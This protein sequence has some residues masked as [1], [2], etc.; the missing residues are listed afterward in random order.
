MDDDHA[1]RLAREPYA[2]PAHALR[3]SGHPIR[4][5]TIRR[6]GAAAVAVAVALLLP[7]A[8]AAAGQRPHAVQDALER[9]V[10]AGAPGAVALAGDR[11]FA[12]GVADAGSGRRLRAGDRVRIGSVTKSFVAVVAL[13]LAGEGRLGL[14][15]TLGRRL[16]GVLPYGDDITLRQL[17]NH[18]SGVPDDVV[19]ALV[20][21]FTGDPLRVW[22][23][24]EIV[25]LVRDKPP[26]FAPGTGWAY[27][28]T[29]YAL[30]GM[31][32][33]QVTGHS[34]GDELEDRIARPLG[35]RHT[36]FPV[37][38]PG[39]G[40]RASRGYSLDVGPG[41]Q[42]VE[43][44]MRDVTV[45]SPSFAWASGNGV[46]TVGDVARFYRA[47]LGGR[48]LAPG[49]LREALDAVPTGRPGR[50]YGLGLNVRDS[51]YGPLV[52]HDGD[53]PGFSIEALSDRHGRRQ[54][55]VAVNMKF[56]APAV[57]AAFD[58]AVDAAGRLTF[59]G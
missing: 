48:L 52:G 43:G 19:P 16:P 11:S 53:V 4:M 29:D 6:S 50:G 58:E 32:I 12:A 38:D 23:P 10:A 9:V 41:G 56:A 49:L 35:L 14:D 26:R 39:L 33:E 2:R 36:S 30:T 28:N 31:M 55:V 42:P 17:L 3:R 44:T 25:D 59:G 57:D 21:V 46:S 45:Y 40:R 18:T 5:L 8:A 1:S 27:S 24:G 15:D 47:L 20:E 13:Q 37:R 34:L 7:A 54:A 22:T 51:P